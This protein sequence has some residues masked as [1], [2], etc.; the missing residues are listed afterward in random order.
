MPNSR[1]LDVVKQTVW[2]KEAWQPGG[3]LAVIPYGGS[4]SLEC[5]IIEI[6]EKDE[7]GHIT[8]CSGRHAI[9]FVTDAD[10]ARKLGD[11]LDAQ[12]EE[13]GRERTASPAGQAEG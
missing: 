11:L 7:L 5:R 8:V 10:T 13:D 9:T 3:V 4:F 1:L 12:E 6:N 2:G